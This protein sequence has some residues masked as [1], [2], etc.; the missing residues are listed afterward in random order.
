MAQSPAITLTTDFGTTDGYAGAVKGVLLSRAPG[1]PLIDLAHDVAP[2]DR[3][4]AFLLLRT[5]V[6]HFPVGTVH[7]VV[8][9]P[10]VGTARRGLVVRAQGQTLVGPDSGILPALFPAAE[11][12]A[13]ALK[14]ARFAGAAPTFHGRDVFAPV[15]AALALGEAPENLADPVQDAERLALPAASRVGNLAKGEVIHVDRFGNLVSNLAARA[16]DNSAH[17]SISVDR[18]PVKF[19][20][21][22]GDVKPGE[23]VAYWGSGGLLE[24]AVR[25]GNARE[26]FGGLGVAVEIVKYA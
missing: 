1:V 10:G 9:D 24:I 11:V 16:L 21:T 12:R 25:D 20:A 18:K 23:T 26:R 14:P 19:A 6:R 8:V 3:V 2:F 4:G 15:A 17:V 13:W 5:A 22:F 7:L